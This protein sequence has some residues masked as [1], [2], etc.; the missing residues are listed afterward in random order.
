[1]CKMCHLL[2]YICIIF[3]WSCPYVGAGV[4][5]SVVA[6]MRVDVLVQDDQCDD[7]FVCVGEHKYVNLIS[8]KAETRRL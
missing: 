6:S 1:M 8:S 7:L 4:F 5:E 2:V 3:E